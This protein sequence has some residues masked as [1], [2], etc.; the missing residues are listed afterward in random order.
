MALDF[1]EF[2]KEEYELRFEKARSL[3]NQYGLE[4]ILVGDE[5]NYRYFTGDRPPT[6]N[7]PTFILLP[8]MG[9][10][11]VIA[12][13]F[14]AKTAKFITYVS[15]VR[16]Y[17]MPFNFGI[18]ADA[19]RSLG[20][21]RVG[22]EYDDRIFG[23]FHSPMQWGEF[24]RMKCDLSN[25][26]FHDAS[27]LLWELR[28]IKTEAEVECLKKAAAITS[29][30][31]RRT[32]AEAKEGMREKDVATLVVS[33]M[34]LLG[35]D[36]PFRGKPG[37]GSLVILDA[38]HSPGE[39]P[40]PTEKP[41]QKGDILHI[42]GGAVYKGYCSDFTR[43][44]VVGEPTKRQIEEWR[45]ARELVEENIGRLKPGVQFKTLTCHFHG[46]G[47]DAIEAPFGGMVGKAVHG[48]WPVREGMVLCVEQ[49]NYLDTGEVFAYEDIA[50]I[51]KDG[52]EVITWADP[53]LQRIRTVG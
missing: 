5:K 35:A 20:V 49:N 13:D 33:H 25:V 14:G 6:K 11:I 1:H 26:E 43:L 3:M 24:D 50:V 44:G 22:V 39:P 28:L 36:I 42:D 19:I 2:S 32:F 45:R 4:A 12:S 30:A 40:I 18:V 16:G 46:I 34:A 53:S 27:T 41:L 9:D 17:P 7:R 15:D 10:P 31:F 23:A 29:E 51:R 37:P 38:N 47:L 8:L 48:E 21:R 52:P